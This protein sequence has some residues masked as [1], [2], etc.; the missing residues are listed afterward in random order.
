[1]TLVADEL[2]GEAEPERLLHEV[3][4][5]TDM[6][7]GQQAMVEPWRGDAD[8]VHRHRRRVEQREPVA[9]LLHL[10][11][12]LHDVTAR[13]VEADRVTHRPLGLRR[14]SL[15]GAP[16]AL[17]RRLVAGE[18]LDRLGLPA[19]VLDPV[20]R[21]FGQD[22][23]VVVVL[24]PPLQVDVTLVAL[25]L[26]QPEDLGVV[27]DAQLEVGDADFDVTETED[28]HAIDLGPRTRSAIAL[29]SRLCNDSVAP[30]LGAPASS[31]HQPQR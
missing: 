28:A 5:V 3:R 20:A 7:S 10:G 12:D 15:H 16:V 6:F 22:H 1:M 24:V 4:H 23:R 2:L 29:R 14:E 31:Q 21:C 27:A 19:D 17:E 26:A 8:E 9:D 25:D 11:V 13:C 30:G 18:I